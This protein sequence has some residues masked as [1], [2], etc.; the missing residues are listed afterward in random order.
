M[1]A[2]L[3]ISAGSF[4]SLCVLIDCDIVE[5]STWFVAPFSEY[6]AAIEIFFAINLLSKFRDKAEHRVVFL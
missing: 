6:V 2:W 5:F 1:V 3:T 4:C